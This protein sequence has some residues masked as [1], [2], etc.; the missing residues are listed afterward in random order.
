MFLGQT[1]SEVSGSTAGP[2]LQDL[3]HFTEI[4]TLNCMMS[5]LDSNRSLVTAI[6]SLGWSANMRVLLGDWQYCAYIPSVMVC[7]I[8]SDTGLSFT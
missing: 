7:H 8:P 5:P 4:L 6:L 2:S 3:I 1:P